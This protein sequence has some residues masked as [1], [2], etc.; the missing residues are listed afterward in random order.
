MSF[1][2]KLEAQLDAARLAEKIR[3]LDHEINY[4]GS[5]HIGKE[6]RSY[7]RIVDLTRERALL[8]IKASE[9]LHNPDEARLRAVAQDIAA[10][11]RHYKVER[12]VRGYDNVFGDFI[13]SNFSIIH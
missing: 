4:E 3:E 7:R 2:R 8:R 1:L 5:R 11:M 12:D 13:D 10:A 9:A 6:T